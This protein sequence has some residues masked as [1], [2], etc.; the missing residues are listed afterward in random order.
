MT[1]E[2]DQIAGL[3]AQ[4][5]AES[6]PA[7]AAD[8]SAPAPIPEPSQADQIAGILLTLGTAGR[9]RFASLETVFTEEKC[10]AHGAA[11]APALERLGIR[12]N[13]GET[14]CYLTAAG[15]VLM[16][17]LESRTAIINDLAKE[18]LIAMKNE[19]DARAHFETTRGTNTG[20]APG[21]SET[22]ETPVHPQV[23]LYR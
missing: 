20:A 12:L 22:P 19:A 6:A 1:T 15:S 8:P 17:A 13:A 9:M 23:N 5:D 16:L 14:M 7:I 3:A 4:V 21:V 2:L 10:K 11:I 18:R